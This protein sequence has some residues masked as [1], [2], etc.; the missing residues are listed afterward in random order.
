[1]IEREH[2]PIARLHR[3]LLRVEHVR[4]PLAPEETHFASR[5]LVLGLTFRP[6]LIIHPLYATNLP[7]AR[8]ASYGS[9][10]ACSRSSLIG[11]PTAKW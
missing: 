4:V 8:S 9:R 5:A 11:T 3:V 10:S 1:M 6:P 2:A 7:S